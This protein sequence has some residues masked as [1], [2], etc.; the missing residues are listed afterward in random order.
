MIKVDGL[1]S[2]NDFEAGLTLIVSL[3]DEI[4][5]FSTYMRLTL[6]EE[7]AIRLV[8]YDTQFIIHPKLQLKIAGLHETGLATPSS[9]IEFSMP[10]LSVEKLRHPSEA[11]RR[12]AAQEVMATLKKMHHDLSIS[13]N[14]QGAKFFHNRIPAVTATHCTTG[15]KVHIML[16]KPFQ[17]AERN[18]A[19]HL[20]QMTL[21][22]P[23]FI[24]LRHFLEIRG[25]TTIILHSVRSYSLL[26]TMVVAALQHSEATLSPED[27]G[28]QLLHVFQ[29]ISSI[30][31]Y[32]LGF[33]TDVPQSGQKEQNEWLGT[34][35]AS[36]LQSAL[37]YGDIRMDGASHVSRPQTISL[38]NPAEECENSGIEAVA[39]KSIQKCL[40]EARQIIL[41]TLDRR[42]GGVRTET[43]SFLDSLLGADYRAFEAGRSKLER[44]TDPMTCNDQDY[45]HARLL[46][47]RSRR[48]SMFESHSNKIEIVGTE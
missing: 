45:S 29:F 43:G 26:T 36:R 8:I 30:D 22:R 16:R 42:E 27:L 18:T 28:G 7:A 10:S 46:A 1:Y 37:S 9:D 38:P 3:T 23:M 11:V 20:K 44:A 19:S 24:I 35:Q 33:P 25:L 40:H 14:F 5:A 17:R 34:W 6:A 15:L 13:A 2:Q 21:L 4:R 32:N 39:I 31:M 41:D 12:A 47:D 48:A